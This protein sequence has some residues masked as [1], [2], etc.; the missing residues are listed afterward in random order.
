MLEADLRQIL[1]N[2]ESETAE[3]KKGL[4][5]PTSLLHD[6]VALANAKGGH[7]VCGVEEDGRVLGIEADRA[8]VDDLVQYVRTHGE[9]P[10]EVTAETV[11]I[12]SHAVVVFSVPYG[13]NKPYTV[14]G[15]TELFVRR[16]ATSTAGTGGDLHRLAMETSLGAFE[17]AP[18]ADATLADLDPSGFDRYLARRGAEAS[19]E[20]GFGTLLRNLGF[21]A[22]PAPTSLGK[23]LVPTVAGLLLFGRTPQ[24]FLPQARVELMRFA[25]DHAD[26]YAERATIEGALPDQLEQAVTFVAQYMRVGMR[27]EGFRRQDIPEYPMEAVSELLLNA[28]IHRD[29]SQRGMAIQVHMFLDRWEIISPGRLPGPLSPADLH[30]R[31][32]RLARNPRLAEGM[33]TLGYGEGLG[34]GLARVRSLLDQDSYPEL[35]LTESPTTVTVTLVGASQVL[36]RSERLRQY[37][38]RLEHQGGNPRQLLVIEHLLRN[39]TMTNADYRRLTSVTQITALRDLNDLVA[40]GLLVRHGAKRGAYYTP[41]NV[42]ATAAWPGEAP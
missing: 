20:L 1:V 16:G 10:L 32:E 23:D 24:R 17:D 34:L 12:G 38:N 31:L 30:G 18:V 21:A 35:A 3:F 5:R 9:P 2:G 37:R 33:R 29:Y 7:I 36:Q 8:S 6:V 41:A 27:I 11:R 22:R 4:P 14:A 19:G 26:R 39:G 28:L 13:W 25:G 15:T 40:R 42:E